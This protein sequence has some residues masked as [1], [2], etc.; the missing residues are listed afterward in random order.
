MTSFGVEERPDIRHRRQQLKTPEFGSICVSF[1]FGIAS[2]R[3]SVADSRLSVSSL[4][5]FTKLCLLVPLTL[6]SFST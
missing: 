5:S 1:F 4:E 6:L 2:R 3:E